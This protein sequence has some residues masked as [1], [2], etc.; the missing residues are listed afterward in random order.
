[1]LQNTRTRLCPAKDFTQRLARI[2]THSIRS[3]HRFCL[4]FLWTVSHGRI[5]QTWRRKDD[6]TNVCVFSRL[7]GPNHNLYG[8]C[9]RPTT[10]LPRPPLFL[11]IYKWRPRP[12]PHA[13]PTSRPVAIT[14]V[15]AEHQPRPQTMGVSSS[16]PP[17]PTFALLFRYF[18]RRNGA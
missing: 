14:L 17:S 4:R 3:F 10:F 6:V 5:S 7:L 1:M 16:V 12:H 18:T 2:D 15:R 9:A 11:A 8:S 13:P